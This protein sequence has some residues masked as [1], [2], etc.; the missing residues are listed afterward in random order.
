MRANRLAVAMGACLL[1]L[2]VLPS[3]ASGHVTIP[4]PGEQGGF[5]IVTFSVPNERPDAGTTTISVQLPT[6]HPLPFVSVQPK[7]GWT[8]ETTM[9]TLDE[10]VDAFGESV[11]EVVDTVT[12]TG[13]PIEAGEFDTFSLSV[14]PLPDDVDELAFPTVQTYSSG[15]E[16]AWIQPTAPGGEEPERPAP[17]LRLLAGE[18]SSEGETDDGPDGG[19]TTTVEESDE[20]ADEPAD[21]QAASAPGSEDD[22]GAEPLAVVALVLAVLAVLLAGGALLT[23]RRGRAS[24]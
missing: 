8:T 6:D 5:S 19:V 23:A 12:W 13:G 1:A 16:V 3:A 4:D 9:R 15:E 24:T 20:P 17:V 2:T 10:P 7:P 11:T 18:G 22:D 14:G 21:E